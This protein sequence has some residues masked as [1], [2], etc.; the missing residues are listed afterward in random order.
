[1]RVERQKRKKIDKDTEIIIRNNS[2]GMFEAP[3]MD[4]NIFLEKQNDEESVTFGELRKLRKFLETMD[5]VIAEVN[6]EE[7]TLYDVIT[8]LRLK[9]YDDYF[10][11][12]LGEDE[13]EFDSI[14]YISPEAFEEFIIDCDQDEFTKVLKTK[15]KN[16]VI[17][18]SVNLYKEH[19]LADYAKM[20][21]IRKTRPYEEQSEFWNDIDE[22]INIK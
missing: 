6:S 21:L 20:T 7:F 5:I 12:V 3:G 14:D 8:A 19:R 18:T 13:E 4:S 17:E 1:M 10:K 9:V 2:H 15:L 22:T 16:Q 11:Y